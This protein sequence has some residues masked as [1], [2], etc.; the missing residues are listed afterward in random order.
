MNTK[1]HRWVWLAVRSLAVTAAVIGLIGAVGMPS[2]SAWAQVN[3]P[4]ETPPSAV[5]APED[6][7]PPRPGFID[8]THSLISSGITGTADR[9]DAFFGDDRI[10]VESN[11]SN[12]KIALLRI[13]DENGLDVK[14]D[15][16]LKI[17]L[18]RLQRR[19]HL[20]IGREDDPEE[21]VQLPGAEKE[22]G[23]VVAGTPRGNLTSAL[24]LMLRSAREIN[25]FIEAGVRF[26]VHPLVFSRIRYRRIVEL[27]RWVLRFTQSVK[28]EEVFLDNSYHWQEIS[29][30]NFERRITPDY[31]FR[32]TL[33]GAW[34]EGLHG[35]FVN[36]GFALVH[37]INERQL[38]VYEWN[39][40]ART[41][42]GVK[43]END[44][45]IVADPEKRFRVEE[46][47]P[48]LRFRQTL[49]WPWFFVE[50]SAERAYR[51]DLDPGADFDGVWR[52]VVKLE[53]QFLDLDKGK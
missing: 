32:A 28:W 25:V 20:V 2:R 34:Y 49:G 39:T 8:R 45:L 4:E 36:Q 13:K 23:P 3:L 44:T 37:T 48:K 14:P 29:Q 43:N 18:P 47:G 7:P 12:L 40:A 26:R 50:T 30:V 52:F 27:D 41:G 35:Y 17:V 53:V 51:R 16:K 22:F 9:I 42:L 33:Q 1:I 31:F 11:R 38:L 10:L 6:E 5:E 46:T 19:L 15:F 21:E 24:R